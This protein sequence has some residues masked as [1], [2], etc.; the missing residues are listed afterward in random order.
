VEKVTRST[1]V[2]CTADS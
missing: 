1:A 2:F